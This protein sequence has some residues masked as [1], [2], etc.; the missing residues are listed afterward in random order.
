MTQLSPGRAGGR[1]PPVPL[2]RQQLVPLNEQLPEFVHRCD[3]VRRDGLSFGLLAAARG[4]A[5]VD[6]EQHGQRAGAAAA[7]DVV[8]RWVG[9]G[10]VGWG[11]WG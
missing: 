4:V 9:L 5:G 6:V 10:W 1:P 3:R 7:D 8:L 2:R 11:W